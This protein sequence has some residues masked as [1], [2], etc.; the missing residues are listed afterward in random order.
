MTPA[1]R[2]LVAVGVQVPRR[3]GQQQLFLAGC[4]HQRA[5]GSGRA[6]DTQPVL[7]LS[8]R[9]LWDSRHQSSSQG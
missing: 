5:G 6:R 4:P 3:L 8:G 1:L 2:H 7:E 9:P